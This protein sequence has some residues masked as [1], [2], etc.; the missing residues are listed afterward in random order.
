IIDSH[1][2]PW[3]AMGVGAKQLPCCLRMSDNTPLLMMLAAWP[4]PSP[5]AIEQLDGGF[6]SH[7]WL[8]TC[9]AG[10]FV[11][12]LAPHSPTFEAG[13]AVAEYL[14]QLGFQAGGPVRTSAGALTVRAGDQALALLRF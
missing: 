11:A 5:I 13:L 7:T 14:E 2:R 4:L 3:I 8:I 6:N 12:K 10:R 1:R 9:G